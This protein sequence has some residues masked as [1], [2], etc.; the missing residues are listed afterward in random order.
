MQDQSPCITI[1]SLNK[2]ILNFNFSLSGDQRLHYPMVY[3]QVTMQ[4]GMNLKKSATGKDDL[5]ARVLNPGPQA[6]HMLQVFCITAISINAAHFKSTVS[7][8]LQTSA[9]AVWACI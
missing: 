7:P 5:S 9:K 1:I 6:E 3:S 8:V 4:L 2:L